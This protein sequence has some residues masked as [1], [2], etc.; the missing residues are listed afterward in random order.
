M[1]EQETKYFDGIGIAIIADY[2]PQQD[3]AMIQ[4]KFFVADGIGKN[5][6]GICFLEFQNGKITIDDFIINEWNRRKGYGRKLWRFVEEYTKQKY[7]PSGFLGDISDV[8]DF[9]I[10]SSFWSKMGFK[11]V[12]KKIHKSII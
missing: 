6:V 2:Y 3:V 1:R 5:R 12:G 8:D 4:F 11:I 10:A 7:A 9:D